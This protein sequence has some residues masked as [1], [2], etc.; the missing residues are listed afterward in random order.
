MLNAFGR[1]PHRLDA[2]ISENV[3]SAPLRDFVSN[4]RHFIRLEILPNIHFQSAPPSAPVSSERRYFLPY[5]S[6]YS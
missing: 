1:F 2:F 3:R 4:A 6:S 5:Y